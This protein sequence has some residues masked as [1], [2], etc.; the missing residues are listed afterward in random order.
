MT[1]WEHQVRNAGIVHLS[2]PHPSRC[3]Q[4]LCQIKSIFSSF[5]NCPSPGSGLH[6]SLS[7]TRAATSYLH[8]PFRPLGLVLIQALPPQEE[9]GM[10]SSYTLCLFP[11]SGIEAPD[12]A[13]SLEERAHF[14]KESGAQCMLVWA[15]LSIKVNFMWWLPG[16]SPSLKTFLCKG[17]RPLLLG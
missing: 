10:W 9:Q 2:F 17:L 1:S 14:Q 11:R 16:V 15:L 3:H 6:H 8:S 4:A 7:G 13:A 12:F 5:S